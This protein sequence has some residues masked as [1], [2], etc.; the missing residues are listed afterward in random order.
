VIILKKKKRG[1]G[2]RSTYLKTKKGKNKDLKGVIDLTSNESGGQ[3]KIPDSGGQKGTPRGSSLKGQHHTLRNLEKILKLD[4]VYS[5]NRLDRTK[6]QRGKEKSLSRI[7]K[8]KLGDKEAAV[9]D[10]RESRKKG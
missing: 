10:S 2:H 9:G 4:L 8:I 6:H 7:K 5:T 3:G 1:S